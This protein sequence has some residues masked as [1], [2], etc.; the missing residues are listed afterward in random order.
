MNENELRNKIWMKFNKK[1]GKNPILKN[2]PFYY[3]ISRAELKN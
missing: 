2:Y 1:N 3:T